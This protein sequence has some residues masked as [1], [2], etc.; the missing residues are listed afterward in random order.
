M[1]G[2]LAHKHELANAAVSLHCAIMIEEFILVT[3][4][5][6]KCHDTDM[7]VNVSGRIIIRASQ[8]NVT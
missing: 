5:L 4:V 1:G 2:C 6:T 8:A 7:K 3:N